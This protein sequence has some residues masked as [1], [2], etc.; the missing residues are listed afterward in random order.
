MARLINNNNNDNK[1]KEKKK[2][3]FATIATEDNEIRH[4]KSNLY[5]QKRERPQKRKTNK[6][7]SAQE[8]KGYSFFFLRLNKEEKCKYV[9]IYVFMICISCMTA[10]VHKVHVYG[11]T[12]FIV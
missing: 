4:D 6:W 10:C 11:S 8:K 1:M 3:F 7:L 9:Y 12:S 5:I 2:R